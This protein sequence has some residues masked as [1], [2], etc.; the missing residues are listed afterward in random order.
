VVKGEGYA[1]TPDFF[2]DLSLCPRGHF[3][4]REDVGYVVF[5]FAERAHAEA[6]HARFGGEFNRAEGPPQAA[7]DR[8]GR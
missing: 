4:W 8:V 5:C 1:T 2:R 6:F 7:Q 3:F